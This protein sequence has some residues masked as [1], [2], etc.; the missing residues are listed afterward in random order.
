MKT[1]DLEEIK[2]DLEFGKSL[3]KEKQ[4]HYQKYPEKTLY[5]I[6]QCLKDNNNRW[7]KR[8]E[9]V[10]KIKDT[11]DIKLGSLGGNLINLEKEGEFSSDKR[12]FN[13]SDWI[14]AN[15][16][17]MEE[18]DKN[19]TVGKRGTLERWERILSRRKIGDHW[20]YKIKNENWEELSEVSLK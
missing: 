11:W 3:G 5:T 10:Q 19:P 2:Q 1:E 6:F 17:M 14:G 18:E 9:V 8:E 16:T 20:S 4:N 13:P 12:K 7:V 15:L